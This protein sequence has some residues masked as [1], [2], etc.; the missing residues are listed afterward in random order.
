M[1]ILSV[2]IAKPS[3]F[4]IVNVP[5]FP[6][7]YDELN[8]DSVIIYASHSDDVQYYN[9]QYIIHH[10]S[11]I[12]MKP[13]Q[14]CDSDCVDID[15]NDKNY[16][17]IM[18]ISDTHNK[19][20]QIDTSKWET[21][22]IDILL[23]SG[24][25]TMSGIYESIVNYDEWIANLKNNNIIQESVVIAG[26]HDITLDT[27]YYVHGVDFDSTRNQRLVDKSKVSQHS[28]AVR[29][30]SQQFTNIKRTVEKFTHLKNLD[31]SDVNDAMK[32]LTA[33]SQL[34]KEAIGRN[35]HYLEDSSVQLLGM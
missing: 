26:N 1:I 15:A 28:G 31:I 22:N 6:S 10:S 12:E 27:D 30:H 3:E 24:D 19:H 14:T 8:V 20:D 32:M 16:V 21:L 29:F 13:V 11:Y 18:C 33:Y 25:S 7:K 2:L 34:C 35:S 23:H 5:S 9:P 17:T 4:E